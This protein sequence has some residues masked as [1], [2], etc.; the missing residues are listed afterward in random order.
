LEAQAKQR[1]LQEYIA[2]GFSPESFE[3][4][5][6]SIRARLAAEKIAERRNRAANPHVYMDGYVPG[7]RSENIAPPSQG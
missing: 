3:T 7:G 5:R 1:A 2:A 6:P 4:G